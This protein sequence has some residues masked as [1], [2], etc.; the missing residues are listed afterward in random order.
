M[1]LIQVS[2]AQGRVPVTVFH[3]QGRVNLG[4]VAEL[5]KMAKDAYDHGMRDLIIDLSQAESLT[6]AGI[7]AIVSIYKMVSGDKSKHLKLVNPIPYIHETLEIAGITESIEVY[8]SLDDAVS[9]F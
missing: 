3:V 6:S 7:R 1:S 9:S 5:E 4:T 8:K 2:Q